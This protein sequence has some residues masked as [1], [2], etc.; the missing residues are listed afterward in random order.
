MK[1]LLDTSAF[2]WIIEGGKKLSRTAEKAFTSEENTPF[3]SV[4]SI[5]EICVKYKLGKL[6]LPVHPLALILP[7]CKKYCIEVLPLVPEEALH[8][9]HLPDM[10][11]DPFDRLLICQ[12]VCQSMSIV[13]N[14]QKIRQYSVQVIW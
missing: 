2:L 7:E 11:G 5:W 1:L 14:D 4:V 9:C 10:H 8:V 12:A 13:S 3:L 6:P